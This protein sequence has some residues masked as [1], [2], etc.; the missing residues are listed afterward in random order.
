MIDENLMRAELSPAERAGQTARR[1]AIYLEL[2]PE[3]GHGAVGR[4]GKSGQV[5]HSFSEA[6]A[7][8]T[9]KDARTVRR[10]A[11]RGEK[12]CDEALS[13]VKGT[14]LDTGAYL[15]KLKKVEG[16]DEQVATV[17]RRSTISVTSPEWSRAPHV[18]HSSLLHV[19]A[20]DHP[21]PR[22]GW[23]KVC[24]RLRVD[25]ID[26]VRLADRLVFATSLPGLWPVRTVL[27]ELLQHLLEIGFRSVFL[28]KP[29]QPVGA[30]PLAE[31]ATE[32]D[33][34]VGKGRTGVSHQRE[35]TPL[36]SRNGIRLQWYGSPTNKA[37]DVEPEASLS[38]VAKRQYIRGRSGDDRFR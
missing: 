6:T 11:E 34:H 22:Q 1:K 38:T 28:G 7:E 36:C 24:R 9:G 10:D 20:A 3:T 25:Q 33:D 13:L 32:P 2:H 19:S 16:A 14:D 18:R 15:D 35:R 26:E 5:V 31:E 21:Q 37:P 23:R 17:R 4:G 29:S 8:S 30:G 27:G 12:V